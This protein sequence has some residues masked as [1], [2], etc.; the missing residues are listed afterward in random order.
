MAHRDKVIHPGPVLSEG[1]SQDY[2]GPPLTFM[3]L[4]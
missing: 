2:T 3:C 1:L 4:V